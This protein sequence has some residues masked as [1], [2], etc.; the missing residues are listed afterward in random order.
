[1]NKILNDNERKFYQ[2]TIDELYTLCPETI[3]KKIPQ[4]NIQQAFVLKTVKNIIKPEDKIL[5]VG[6][7]EDTA[8][9]SLRKLGYNIIEIDTD[10]SAFHNNNLSNNILNIN[11][12]N[13]RLNNVDKK[14][15]IIIATSVIEH[16]ENDEEFIDDIC[17]LLS[18]NGIA[19]LTCDFND[20][21]I[22]GNNKPGVDYRLYTKNDLLIRLNNVLLANNC[23]IFG[24]INYDSTPDFNYY[25]C[26][27]SF[28]SYVF[29]NNNK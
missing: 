14:F 17:K 4:A 11:L 12:H 13:Y 18:P 20:A 3:K 6:A 5:S 23:E 9:E 27:Y 21:Y 15:D 28:A 16:V 29:K 26:V 22:I 10:D 19:I 8:S 24:D 2:D 25:G 1:M 7:Y